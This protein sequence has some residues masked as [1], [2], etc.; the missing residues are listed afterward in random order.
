MEKK[1]HPI[2]KHSL[3]VLLVSMAIFTSC[4]K[5]SEIGM[6]SPELSFSFDE[7]YAFINEEIT[8][9]NLS[10]NATS[11]AWEFGDGTT[12]TEENPKH[13]YTEAGIFKVVLVGKG[14]GGSSSTIQEVEIIHP[15]PEVYM[16]YDESYAIVDEE[17]TFDNLCVNSI[18]YSWDFGDGDTST[19][20]SPKH[21]YTEEGEYTI[22][23]IATGEGGEVKE[24]YTI[25]IK[26]PTIQG[27]WVLLE[28]SYDGAILTN[29]S[30][31]FNVTDA[32]N[33]SAEFVVGKNTGKCTA[34]YTKFSPL[35]LSNIDSKIA[36]INGKSASGTSTMQLWSTEIFCDKTVYNNYL[37]IGLGMGK[38]ETSFEG[39][40]LILQS[41]D[42]LA[43][44]KYQK[45]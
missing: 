39:R 17:I 15:E 19:E 40:C 11:Y 4:K 9:K 13:T 6:P 14:D 42:G 21:T 27:N 12:S 36:I 38:P 31:F 20:E 18:S 30:G 3:L 2:L 23:L 37:M 8:F 34:K 45:E 25:E 32:E 1:L 43:K 16:S 5:D 22:T 10:E 35:F 41:G 29:A 44:L 26:L 24:K 28:A 7:S 33:Y